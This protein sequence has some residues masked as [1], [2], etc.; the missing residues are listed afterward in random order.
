MSGDTGQV[1]IHAAEEFG[2]AFMRLEQLRGVGSLNQIEEARESYERAKQTLANLVIDAILADPFRK[3]FFHRPTV[4]T[5]LERYL[6]V[7][8]IPRRDQKEVFQAIRLGTDV[9][10]VFPRV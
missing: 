4:L 8:G 9:P 1:V 2:N 6:A 7:D 5:R 3:D 10:R